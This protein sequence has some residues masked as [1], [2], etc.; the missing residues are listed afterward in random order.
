MLFLAVAPQAAGQDPERPPTAADAPP[1]N[2]KGR[3][4]RPRGAIPAVLAAFDRYDI[5]GMPEAHGM[6]DVD[7]FILSL[8]RHP[9]FPR[10]VNDIAVECGNSLYQPILDRYFA[11]ENVP[12]TEVSVVWRNTTQP[13]CSLSGFFQ[14]L[15]PFVRKIN[16][17][18]PA[19]EKLRV[20]AGDSPID[21][22]EVKTQAASGRSTWTETAALPR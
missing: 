5:V 22:D 15:F 17:T 11:G 9:D 10:K 21:W 6:K 14:L 20:L 4:P 3:N 16:A 8:I 1:P 19:G 7:D 18:L 2:L 13:M 12:F